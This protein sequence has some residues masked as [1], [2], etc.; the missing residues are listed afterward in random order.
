VLEFESG[1]QNPHIHSA[2]T[3][4]FILQNLEC[5]DALL[6]TNNGKEWQ[7]FIVAKSDLSAHMSVRTLN[8][9]FVSVTS[10]LFNEPVRSY[11]FYAKKMCP[12]GIDDLGEALMLI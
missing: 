11:Y 12:K 6:V 1:N 2:N 8:D 5:R 3:A 4:N 9:Q 7:L 10:N